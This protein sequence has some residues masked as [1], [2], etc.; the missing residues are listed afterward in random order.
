ME[1]SGILRRFAPSYVRN[2]LSDI[3]TRLLRLESRVPRIE[4]LQATISIL[5]ATIDSG[6]QS[7]LWWPA[8]DIGFNGQLRRKEIFSDLLATFPFTALVETGTWTGDTTGYLA[9]T[10]RLPVFSG[11]LSYRF[12]S[13]AKRRLVNFPGITLRN[14]DS[15][16]FLTDLAAEDDLRQRATFFYLDAHWHSDLPLAE[17][18]ELI[19][20]N[21]KNFVIMIDDFAVPGDAGYG[22][23]DYGEGKALTMEYIAPVMKRND[24]AAYYPSA[25]SE[26]ETGH[27]RGSIV[28][29]RRG[30]ASDALN[31]LA[32]LKPA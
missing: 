19:A 32:S 13:L 21:W 6:M 12:H 20:V 31:G 23:D 3:Q 5:E 16:R 17:E 22:F 26:Q 10:S 24:L 2:Y 18:I 4:N 15:R 8:D 14:A 28:L 27:K 7:P 11:E 29:V 30:V 9:E 25:A 1:L